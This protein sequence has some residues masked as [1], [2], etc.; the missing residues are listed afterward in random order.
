MN[1]N[2]S[3]TVFM[4]FNWLQLNQYCIRGPLLS[5]TLGCCLGFPSPKWRENEERP[6]S[7]V[8]FLQSFP[9]N[10]SLYTA[11]QLHDRF[12]SVL[13]YNY[14]VYVC[15]YER[16]GEY[17][18]SQ[19]IIVCC[20]DCV[21]SIT[22]FCPATTCALFCTCPRRKVSKWVRYANILFRNIVFYIIR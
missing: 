3:R 18:W 13:Y 1:T 9:L 15:I 7:K 20:G 8:V 19:S 17:F 6:L 21:T 16:G 2:D 22:N 5:S 10:G 14:Y 4:H 11:P 12:L